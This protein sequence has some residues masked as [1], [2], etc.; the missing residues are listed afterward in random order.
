MNDDLNKFRECFGTAAYLDQ[1]TPGSSYLFIAAI[2]LYATERIV[3]AIHESKRSPRED[4]P[5]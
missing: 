1:H 2:I 4:D 5:T 3:E